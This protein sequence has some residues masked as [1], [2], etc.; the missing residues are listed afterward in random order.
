MTEPLTINQAAA[1]LGISERTLRKR[2]ARGEVKAEKEPLEAGGVA[3][4]VWLDGSAPEVEPEAERKT[5]ERTGSAP[6]AKSPKVSEPMSGT[7][8][9]PEVSEP[10]AGSEPEARIVERLESEVVFL[11]SMLEARE[12]DAAELRAALREALKAMPKALTSGSTPNA[13]KTGRENAPQ[14]PI[15]QPG[16]QT[17]AAPKQAAQ[18]GARVRKPKAW[19]RVAARILGIPQ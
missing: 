8:T 11:R 7:E 2:I 9:A 14:A 13:E 17:P 3:W 18:R 16:D 1:R 10:R 15:I 5:E 19:Q 6:E 12:R 4:R